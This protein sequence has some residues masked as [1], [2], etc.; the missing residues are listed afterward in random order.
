MAA[1][2]MNWKGFL[3]LP[4]LSTPLMLQGGF[5]LDS[6]SSTNSNKTANQTNINPRKRFLSPSNQAS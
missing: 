6:S 3:H 4:S 1:N 2:F 5:S